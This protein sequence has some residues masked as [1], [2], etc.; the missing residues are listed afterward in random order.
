[1]SN[2]SKNEYVPVKLPNG[3]VI[4]IET[5]E[6]IGREDVAFT[7]FSFE[8]IT[9]ALQGITEAI[10]GTIDKV[11][12]QKTIVKFGLEIGVESGGLSAMIVKGSGKGNLEISIEWGK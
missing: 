3:A 9:D 4:K 6:I 7:Q 2:E 1:M 12:P 11:K 10:K 5:S 8:Q